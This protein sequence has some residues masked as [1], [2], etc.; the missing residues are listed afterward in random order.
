[1]KTSQQVEKELEQFIEKFLPEGR[2][3]VEAIKK[4]A[5][6]TAPLAERGLDIGSVSDGQG[7]Q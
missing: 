4:L 1:M 3:S 5:K 6:E 2:L 7:S